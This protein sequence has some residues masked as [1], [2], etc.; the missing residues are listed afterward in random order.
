MSTINVK[1][2]YF[3]Y[4]VKNS[5][6][7]MFIFIEYCGVGFCIHR[8]SKDPNTFYYSNMIM[9]VLHGVFIYIYENITNMSL[10]IHYLKQKIP[11]LKKKSLYHYDKYL[12]CIDCFSCNYYMFLLRL[13]YIY[14]YDN[15]QKY[16]IYYNYKVVA[17]P[18]DNFESLLQENLDIKMVVKHSQDLAEKIFLFI[19]TGY[20][21]REYNEY[22]EENTIMNV[23]DMTKNQ[24]IL[25]SNF[26]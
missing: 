26:V 17:L 10:S 21:I 1:T 15:L 18:C 23:D 25:I 9:N 11:T 24:M 16:G 20:E 3:Y 13:A 4:D 8:V 22:I 14:E 6:Y 19:S 5:V 2:M 12:K 7:N